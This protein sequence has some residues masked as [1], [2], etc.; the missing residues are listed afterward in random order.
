MVTSDAATPAVYLASL[1]EDR[2]LAVTALRDT[3]NANLPDGFEE[4]MSYGMIAWYVPLERF[5]NTYNGH[6]LG[7]AGV[8]SQKN[9]ISLYL[10]SVYGDR[11]TEAWFKER[12]AQS[13][14]Q[15]NMGKSCVRFRNLE[16]I[17]LDVVGET[18]A[19]VDL[20]SYLAHYAQARG[21]YRKT[22]GRD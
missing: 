11:E 22:R 19:R 16:E 8:A 21:S 6:P 4:G 3:I 18:I 2:R 5:G 14:K 10:L 15:L 20:D 17:P 7:L 13:G 12:Y 9:Y 1:Q